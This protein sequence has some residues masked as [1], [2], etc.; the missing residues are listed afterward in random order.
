M[1]IY[2]QFY[3]A[4]YQ[5]TCKYLY[6]CIKKIGVIR[7]SSLPCIALEFA[8]LA[9]HHWWRRVAQLGGRFGIKVNINYR[10]LG[11]YRFHRKTR[12]DLMMQC[13]LIQLELG[14]GSGLSQCHVEIINTWNNIYFCTSCLF[15]VIW[16]VN[17]KGDIFLMS[18][19]FNKS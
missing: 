14:S 7:G 5:G 18:H 15:P 2:M 1:I 3:H 6:S 4:L 19:S 11:G 9:L 12:R 13:F 10:A 8:P 16:L 17:W